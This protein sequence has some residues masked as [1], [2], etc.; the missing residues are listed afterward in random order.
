MGA[1]S[2]Q[3]GRN[4]TH[5]SFPP[6][7]PC[8]YFKTMKN[9]FKYA[10]VFHICIFSQHTSNRYRIVNICTKPAVSSCGGELEKC[11]IWSICHSQA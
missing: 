1:T 5:L 2:A 8:F 11:T 3:E 9:I 6:S 10:Y 4:I 7:H